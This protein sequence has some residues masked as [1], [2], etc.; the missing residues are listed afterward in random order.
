MRAILKAPHDHP[1]EQMAHFLA[2]FNISARETGRI[3]I[4]DEN[5]LRSSS[6]MLTE[7]YANSLGG[8]RLWAHALK[9]HQ[10]TICLSIRNY[11]DLI[12]SAYSQLLRDGGYLPFAHVLEF[13]KKTNPSWIDLIRAIQSIFIDAQIVVWSFESYVQRPDDVFRYISKN[14]I[15][16]KFERRSN[17]LAVQRLT[18]SN[19]DK[20]KMI[21]L[22]LSIPA[23]RNLIKVICEENDGE[24]F[25]P[26]SSEEKR[27]FTERYKKE[28]DE[29][30]KM[31][32]KFIH[33]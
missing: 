17:P 25:D 27:F 7:L 3:L 18:A 21:S 15:V 4:S 6:L 26:L 29:I 2:L 19:I 16:D 31:N 1:D 8:L 24:V 28:C 30:S 32:L 22:K 13:W 14:V 10:K 33:V 20:I 12:P 23:R 9:H 11:S 5:I